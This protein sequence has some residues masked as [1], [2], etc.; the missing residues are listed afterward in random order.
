MGVDK[1]GYLDHPDQEKAK[2]VA[3]VEA[4]IEHDIY[5]IIDWHVD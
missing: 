3:V 4:A 1:G 2:M 5:V